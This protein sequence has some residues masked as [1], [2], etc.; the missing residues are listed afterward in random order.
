MNQTLFRVGEMGLSSTIQELALHVSR[1]KNKWVHGCLLLR[2]E[3]E[4]E[5]HATGN[6]HAARRTMG[7]RKRWLFPFSS[8]FAR[9]KETSGN[10]AEYMEH[11]FSGQIERILACFLLRA[12]GP[13]KNQS[14]DKK[15][16]KKKHPALLTS[17]LLNSPTKYLLMESDVLTGNVRLRSCC[18]HL[19]FHSRNL[20]E[21]R[22]RTVSAVVTS[23]V[24]HRHF[25]T[26]WLSNL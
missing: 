15:Y 18:V 17:R 7:E 25:A 6:E 26:F 2:R 1:Q 21:T 22:S 23:C 13:G 14:K 20:T 12:S 11:A 16:L 10:V 5:A 9:A 4:R 24:S 19:S 8:S 3:G